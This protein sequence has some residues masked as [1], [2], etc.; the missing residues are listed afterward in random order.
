MLKATEDLWDDRR[1]NGLGNNGGKA[2]FVLST[3]QTPLQEK[4]VCVKE[5]RIIVVVGQK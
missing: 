5:K 2:V 3:S 1:C 4:S